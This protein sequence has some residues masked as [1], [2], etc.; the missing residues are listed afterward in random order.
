MVT[1][2]ADA[3]P[4]NVVRPSVAGL[5]KVGEVLT[6]APGT[7]TGTAPISYSY[8]W[9]RCAPAVYRTLVLGGTPL[10]FWRLADLDT[11]VRDE[12]GVRTG[13]TFNGVY[14]GYNG[15][16]VGDSDLATAFDGT[17]GYVDFPLPS[18]QFDSGDFTIEGW[19]LATA[20]AEGYGW[21]NGFDGV[22]DWYTQ[23]GTAPGGDVRVH[24]R[25]S[26]ARTWIGGPFINDAQWHHLVLTRAGT[27]LTVY[28]D[29]A[30][31]S[32]AVDVGDVDRPNGAL[33]FGHW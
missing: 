32:A 10:H 26:N 33:R 3:P 31:Y 6:A 23:I 27:R 22:T 19:Y 1:A 16:I 13:Q 14:R 5:T 9:Q 15:A 21:S 17:S 2:D 20:T 7:W 28:V 4:E 24:I 25:G 12:L 18:L 8:Q 11:G 30:P 29:G